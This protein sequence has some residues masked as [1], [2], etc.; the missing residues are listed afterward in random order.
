MRLQGTRPTRRLQGTRPTRRKIATILGVTIALVFPRIAHAN[1]LDTF[2][3]G[4][5][6]TAMSGAVS[7]DVADFSA[8]Y[9][10]PAGLARA[11][12]LEISIGYFRAD[13]FL[14]IDGKENAIDP[15]RGI[16]AGVVAPGELFKIPFAFG[17]GLHLPDARISRIRALP[18]QTPRW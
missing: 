13:H 9:Y 14:K 3:F 2:G 16:V 17:L 10:N 8:N 4:S 6:E 7:A 1:P 15:V 11:K 5:R 18:Q 12:S